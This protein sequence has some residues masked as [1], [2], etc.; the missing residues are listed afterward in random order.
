MIFWSRV[1]E[2][3]SVPDTRIVRP[4][5]MVLW[6]LMQPITMGEIFSTLRKTKDGAVGL[7]KIL[8]KDISKLDP[9][10]LQAHFNLWLYAEYQPVE[11]HALAE[12]C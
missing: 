6:G 2:E 3:E 12:W 8:R 1:F 10:A 11:N 9:R 5:G 7:D 4:Q